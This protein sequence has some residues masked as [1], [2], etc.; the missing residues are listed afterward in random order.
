MLG[1]L[2]EETMSAVFNSKPVSVYLCNNFL[3]GAASGATVLMAQ[4]WGKKDKRSISY[5]LGITL[6]VSIFVAM[7][8]SI[9]SLIFSDFVMG[10]FTNEDNLIKYGS[11]YLKDSWI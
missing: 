4:Y 7:I 2:S 8:F 1:K 6:A 3:F 10:V 9:L 11:Q 5:V